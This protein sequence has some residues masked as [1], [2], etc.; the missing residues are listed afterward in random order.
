MLRIPLNN[1]LIVLHN[2]SILE[3]SFMTQKMN[4]EFTEDQE[5]VSV[6][7]TATKACKKV[8]S[9]CVIYL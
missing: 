7:A 9:D 8:E 4:L 3:R 2:K 5:P 6:M 1:D